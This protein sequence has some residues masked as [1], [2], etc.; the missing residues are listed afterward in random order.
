MKIKKYRKENLEFVELSNSLFS[1]ILCNLGASIFSIIFNNELMTMTPE[2][3]SDFSL[4]N[5]YNGKTIGRTS[6]RIK[7]NVIQI[8]GETF[9]LKNNEDKNVLH[10]GAD[11]ISNKFFACDVK[12]GSNQTKVQFKYTSK[13]KESGFPGALKLKVTYVIYEKSSKFKIIFEA[14]TTKPTLC[15]LTNHTFFTLGEKS[16]DSLCLRLNGS[17]YIECDSGD[18]TPIQKTEVSKALDFRKFKLIGKDI[19]KVRFGKANGYDHCYFLD[20]CGLKPQIVLKSE[21]Y[22]LK[23]KTDFECCQI[24][25]DNYTNDSINWINLGNDVN[26]SVAIE[27]CDSFLNRK[28]LRP[29]EKYKHFI[30]YEFKT[31]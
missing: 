11:A 14:K 13:N 29:N 30:A 28:V 18:L 23:I 27:P 2:N 9:K 24:Y 10:G 12:E 15:N 1:I 20:E 8:D 5:V 6:N 7:G 31:K 16:I 17:N 26:R 21:K 4:A 22:A 3:V 19:E 25:S